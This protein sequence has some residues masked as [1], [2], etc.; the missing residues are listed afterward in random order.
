[1]DGQLVSSL[2]TYSGTATLGE[3]APG[4]YT[5][6]VRAKDD[7]SIDGT[8]RDARHTSFRISEGDRII[9]ETE[10]RLSFILDRVGALFNQRDAL[11]QLL[12]QAL[13]DLEVAR[14]AVQVLELQLES[15]KALGSQPRGGIA[16]SA[17]RALASPA[18][19]T[20]VAITAIPVGAF[21]GIEAAQIQARATLEAANEQSDLDD[22]MAACLA[23]TEKLIHALDVTG[24]P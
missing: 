12:D 18:V 1:L 7:E 21:V 22:N 17:W 19:V 24:S 10:L 5:F 8:W 13:G 4:L 20:L 23:N 2:D 14:S 3:L 11:Q 9:E 15:L 16:R 6:R